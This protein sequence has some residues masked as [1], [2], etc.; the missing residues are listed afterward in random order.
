[1]FHYIIAKSNFLAHNKTLH[2]HDLL[3]NFC[4]VVAAWLVFTPNATWC[5]FFVIE[6]FFGSFQIMK[7]TSR[8]EKNYNSNKANVDW[9]KMLN[10]KINP[11]NIKL[12]DEGPWVFPSC[13]R[14]FPYNVHPL[15]CFNENPTQFCVLCR[16]CSILFFSQGYF[17]RVSLFRK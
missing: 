11:F 17:W 12:F 2:I 8:A 14:S 3:I 9:N 1:M 10:W 16:G 15:F 13:S 6:F 4:P 5:K 7:L